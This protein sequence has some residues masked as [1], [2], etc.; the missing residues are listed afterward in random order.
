MRTVETIQRLGGRP[1]EVSRDRQQDEETGLGNPCAK[2]KAEVS[3]V[4]AGD[5][6]AER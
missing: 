4:Q 5:D 1:K 6:W 2:L 3:A